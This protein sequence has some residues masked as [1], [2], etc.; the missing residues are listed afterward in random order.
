MRI[1]SLL[2][3]LVLGACAAPLKP[4][5]PPP[6]RSAGEATHTPPTISPPAGPALASRAQLPSAPSANAGFAAWRMSFVD[7]AVARGFDRGFVEAELASVTPSPAIL[8]QDRGQPEF[9][10]PISDYVRSAA[11]PTKAAEGVRRMAGVA[12]LAAIEARYGVP[13][14]ILAAIW[15]DESDFGR[16]QGDHDVITAFATLAYQGRRRE[17]AE[18]QLI[19]ALVILR[20]RGVPRAQLK[21]S[22]AGAMGETQFIPEAYLLYGQDADGDGRVNIWTSDADALA[23]AANHLKQQGWRAGESWAVEVITPPGVDYSLAEG[24][25]HPP[26]WWA[27][28]GLI[29]AD[30]RAW[31]AADSV[32]EAILLLPAG[33]F[34][35][36]FLAFP[37][38]FVIR[39]Y[40]N[41]IAYALSIGLLADEMR[42]APPL[43]RPWPHEIPLSREQRA[44]AQAS[45][46]A[47]GF[48]IGKID[49]LI[50]AET[51]TALRAWQKKSGLLAD[52]YLTP[53]IVV[54]LKADV[55]LRAARG[56]NAQ[57]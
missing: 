35:P 42:G 26:A 53:A 1:R 54:R 24:E 3:L 17:W 7:K 13:R 51:R 4:A 50:G 9:S 2:P 49:G 52:G 27:Q 32:A 40:N 37:N 8:S 39:K 11:S 48:P 21:G 46:G 19:D 16:I 57:R 41:S 44:S 31:S 43:S 25:A 33:A 5:G 23:T 18:T 10:R 20:D 45:L 28:K 6:L 56:A 15:A 12:Q 22:W 29:R 36:A 38:H 30:G 47:L 34:G 55:D 14:E